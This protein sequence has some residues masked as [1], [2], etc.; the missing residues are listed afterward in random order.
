MRNKNEW[1]MV[2]N[3]IQKNY[4]SAPDVIS[5]G[6]FTVVRLLHSVTGDHSLGTEVVT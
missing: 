4:G 3:G 5:I 2:S 1:V 6:K